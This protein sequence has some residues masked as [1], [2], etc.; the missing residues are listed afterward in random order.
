MPGPS[1]TS[2]LKYGACDFMVR[3]GISFRRL[4]TKKSSAFVSLKSSAQAAAEQP[5]KISR[6]EAPN[7]A[8]CHLAQVPQGL[9]RSSEAYN[10][11]SERP[12]GREINRSQLKNVLASSLWKR[13]TS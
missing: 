11:Q 1:W 7:G 10:S 8:G 12:G 5:P 3:I 13:P 4:M 2:I 6:A 9:C